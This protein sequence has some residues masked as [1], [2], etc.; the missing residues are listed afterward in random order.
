MKSTI[1]HTGGLVIP[2]NIR[3]A[4]AIKP[5]M[6]LNVRRENGKIAITPARLA[7]KLERKGRLLVAVSAKAVPRLSTD[8]VE[9]TR[10]RSRRERANSFT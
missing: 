4:S 6:P 9:R 7:V 10:Q 5:G 3:C 8:A 2:K 1:G